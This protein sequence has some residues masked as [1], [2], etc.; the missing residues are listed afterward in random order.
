MSGFACKL[1]M[2]PGTVV[3]K[4]Q[5]TS[6][7]TARFQR[8]SPRWSAIWAPHRPESR[9]QCLEP[10]LHRPERDLTAL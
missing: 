8:F 5:T 1:Y 4:T 10:W 6:P 9:P 2:R 3:P 7:T